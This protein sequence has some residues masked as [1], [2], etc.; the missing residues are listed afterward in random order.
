MGLKKLKKKQ[1]E[2]ERV[3][4]KACQIPRSVGRFEAEK[5][6]REETHNT[7]LIDLILGLWEGLF[8]GKNNEQ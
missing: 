7:N 6:L 5:I 4:E 8:H 1:N 2:Y 3:Y